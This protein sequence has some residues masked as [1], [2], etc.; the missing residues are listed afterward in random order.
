MP[1]NF[2]R[3]IYALL[4][5]SLVCNAMGV[6]SVRCCHTMIIASRGLYGLTNGTLSC[7]NIYVQTIHFMYFGFWRSD[8]GWIGLYVHTSRSSCML[9]SY[10][11]KLHSPAILWGQWAYTTFAP[12]TKRR[13]VNIPWGLQW[14]YMMSQIKWELL[15]SLQVWN[16]EF[17]PNKDWSYI[18]KTMRGLYFGP[19]IL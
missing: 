10:E 8:H 7:D 11:Y 18:Y 14:L 17:V 3:V 5:H 19:P 9:L 1:Y 4:L 12:Q 13:H 16:C 15:E 2:Y 6:W